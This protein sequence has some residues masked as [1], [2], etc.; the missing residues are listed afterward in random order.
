[1]MTESQAFPLDD[2]A[3]RVYNSSQISMSKLKILLSKLWKASPRGLRWRAVAL[4]N[5]RFVVGVTGIVWNARG[6]LLLAHHI[7]RD[8][9]AWG[10]P[11][12]VIRRGES[13]EQA[14]HREIREETGLSARVGHLV[15]VTLDQRWPNLTCH[16]ICTV[17]GTPQPR[18]NSE[19]FEAGFYPL[20]ALPGAISPDQWAII[21]YARGVCE[22]MDG[23]RELSERAPIILTAQIGGSEGRKD[24]KTG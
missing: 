23:S 7:Y 24:G 20:D 8:E 6:E 22:Q 10:P 14:L 11:G 13:L 19:L 15:Q 9:I 16:F 3:P 2:F 12:G 1:M 17:E 5:D 4:L 18:V 21:Q